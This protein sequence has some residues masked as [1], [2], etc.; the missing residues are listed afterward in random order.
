MKV[1]N[2]ALCSFGMSGLVFHA[3]FIQTHP[4]FNLYAV[5][6]RSAKTAREK[7]PSI[8]SFDT[9]EAM[10][11]D[12]NIDLVIVNTPNYTHFDF[13][14]KAL[15]AGRHVLVEKSF[16]VTVSEAEELVALAIQQDKKLAVFQN[17]RYDSDFKTVKKVV[18]GGELGNIIEAEF[19]FDRFRPALSTKAHKETDIPGAGLLYDLGPHLVDQSICLFGMPQSLFGFLKITR[20]G[21]LVNDYLDILLFYPLLTVR[22]KSGYMV[23]EPIP[24]YILH[25]SNGSFLKPRADV[26]EDALKNGEIPTTSGW[27]REPATAYG[28]L[29]T[30]YGSETLRQLVI[31]EDGNYMEFYKGLYEAIV[32]DIDP[33]VTGNDGLNVLKIIEA[34]QESQETKKV[35]TIS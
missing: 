20:P 4:G 29:N 22:L 8:K 19:H 32:N 6:E 7:Y 33:P 16:T 12:D 28:L 2:T 14:K 31:S 25:G 10:L 11:A 17:R 13:A 3:P 23:K 21:S 1:I 35:I 15:L 18:N 30:L 5:W 27:G 34:I 26:Q 9:L 24:S